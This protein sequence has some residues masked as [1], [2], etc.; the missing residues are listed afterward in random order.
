VTKD[1]VKINKQEEKNNVKKMIIIIA[2]KLKNV[3]KIPKKRRR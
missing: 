1:I 2:T 3:R